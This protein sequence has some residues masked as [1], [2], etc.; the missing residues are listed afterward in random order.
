[1]LVLA[2]QF[3][4]LNE[5]SLFLLLFSKCIEDLLFL[6]LIVEGGHLDLGLVEAPFELLLLEPDLEVVV[7]LGGEGGGV[8]ALD[9]FLEILLLLLRGDCFHVQALDLG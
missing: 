1:M 5:L 8:V 6:L 3:L 2:L 4:L 9:E 7:L